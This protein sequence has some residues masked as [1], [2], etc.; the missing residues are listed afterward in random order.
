MQIG[1]KKMEIAVGSPE[2]E[3]VRVEIPFFEDLEAETRYRRAISPDEVTVV[4]PTLNEA[5]AIGIVIAELNKAGFHNILIVD[6]YSSYTT[7]QVAAD[8]KIPSV[9]QHGK[10]KT[11]A[12]QTAIEHVRTRYIVV[13]DG[14]STYRAEDIKMFLI[15]GGHY[16]QIIGARKKNGEN[17]N[18]LHRIGNWV[19]TK[20]FNLLMGTKLSDVCS[21]MYMLDAEAARRLVLDTAGFD[22]EVEIAAQMS[23]LG[24]I[25][26]VPVEYRKRVGRQKIST[27]RSGIAIGLSILKL[28][29]KYNPAFLLSSL[30]SLAGIPGAAILIWVLSEW[31]VTGTLRTGW[32]IVGG[33][34]MLFASQA[35]TLG[36]ISLMLRRLEIRLSKNE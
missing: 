28:A 1:A 14:D 13:V 23:K 27:W 35:F 30:A 6:G 22:V 21:G 16:D 33:M 9:L 18:R 12:I 4:I 24:R 32:A 5:E 11:G 19:I 34:L 2:E 31:L 36:T 8:L 25:T 7:R 15:H 29:R 17:N 20:S 3:K 26:E 10:G